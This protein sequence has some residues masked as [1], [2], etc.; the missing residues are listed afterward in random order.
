MT[1]VVLGIICVALV[2]IVEHLGDVF[3]MSISMAGVTTGTLIGFFT[4]GMLVPSANYKGC[5][6]GGITG[7]VTTFWLIMGAQLHKINGTLRYNSLPTSTDNCPYPMNMT[8]WIKP[9][10]PPIKPDDEPMILFTMSA[11]YYPLVGFIVVVIT[12]TIAS[13]I[14]GDSDHNELNRDHFSPLIQRY[15]SHSITPIDQ[16][17]LHSHR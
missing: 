5:V 3:T 11:L 1:V 7:F 8:D 10:L 9:T 16:K 6:I 4:L 15:A 13:F 17:I 12:G 2:L 14:T